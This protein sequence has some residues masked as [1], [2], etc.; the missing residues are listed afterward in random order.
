MHLCKALLMGGL[1]IVLISVRFWTKWL[2]A[3]GNQCT[4]AEEEAGW[5]SGVC[6]L[7]LDWAD[8]SWLLSLTSSLPKEKRLMYL[9]FPPASDAFQLMSLKLSGQLLHPRGT[10]STWFTVYFLTWFFT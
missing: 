9:R 2:K 7:V 10:L 4:A 8:L 3:Q 1:V 5:G 6:G